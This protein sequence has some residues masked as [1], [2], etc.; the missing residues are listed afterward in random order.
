MNQITIPRLNNMHGHLRQGELLKFLTPFAARQ[1]GYYVPMGNTKPPILTGADAVLYRTEI[2]NAVPE[3]DENAFKPVLSI[4]IREDT[5]P[6]IIH[7]AAELGVKMG[8]LY[9]YARTTHADD[10]IKNYMHLCKVFETM[11]EVGMIAAFH[12][13][14]PN[15]IW[16]DAECEYAFWGIFES[17]Y[18]LFPGLKMTWE[19]LSDTR[20]LPSLLDISDRVAFTITLHHMLIR[21]VDV[22]ADSHNKC[23]PQAKRS[24][25][26]SELRRISTSGHPKAILGLDDAPWD[27]EH[28]ACARSCNGCWTM[29]N[30]TEML[31]EVFHQEGM[32]VG[33]NGSIND[34]G[35]EKM[36]LFSSRN[37]ARFYNLPELTNTITL[38]KIP[39][40]VQEKYI[41]ENGKKEF[42][43]FWAGRELSWII[44]G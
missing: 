10:G 19:H 2:M 37:G 28:K 5:S 14:H 16:D 31:A 13:E 23:R 34:E 8:K 36:I 26:R 39:S 35:V 11:E 15:L 21:D 7:G 44:V 43:P 18:S 1:C 32:L 38:A 41:D 30:A 17:I 22:N 42:V 27:E 40:R 3:R 25:D 9:P 12:P 24:I 33:H 20:V 4:K 6:G 29:P